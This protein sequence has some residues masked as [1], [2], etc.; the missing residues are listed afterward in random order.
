MQFVLGVDEEIAL[1]I[2][3]ALI[4]VG[5]AEGMPYGHLRLDPALPPYLLRDLGEAEQ[6]AAY[7]EA[8][9]DI[10][11]A[12]WRLGRVL[13]MGGEAEAALTPLGAVELRLLLESLGAS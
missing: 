6:E 7:L 3:R 1:A 4:E 12:H 8:G 2:G 10:A 13:S 5:L 11:M 9:Y